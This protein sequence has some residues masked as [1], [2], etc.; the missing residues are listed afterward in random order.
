M[1]DPDPRTPLDDDDVLDDYVALPFEDEGN[2]DRGDDA[3]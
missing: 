1:T 2:E 3:S